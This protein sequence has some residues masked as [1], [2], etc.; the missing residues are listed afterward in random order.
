MVN[1]RIAPV[2]TLGAAAGRLWEAYWDWQFR[3]FTRTTLAALDRRALARVGIDPDE[4]E[5]FLAG[6][7]GWRR[8]RTQWS[9]R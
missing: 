6:R 8:G 1:Q 5:R 2:R 3:R 7:P 4:I 9:S